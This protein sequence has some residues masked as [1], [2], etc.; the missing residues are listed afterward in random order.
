MA[1]VGMDSSCC[2]GGGRGRYIPGRDQHG[3]GKLWGW[4]VGGEGEL[5][6]GIGVGQTTFY[7]ASIRHNNTAGS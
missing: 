7:D 4:R 5:P 6:T 3:I 1:K 2:C